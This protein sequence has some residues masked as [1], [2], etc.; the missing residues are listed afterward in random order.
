MKKRGKTSGWTGLQDLG[1]SS[2]P[3][4]GWGEWGEGAEQDV[5]LGDAFQL[6]GISLTLPAPL[7]PRSVDLLDRKEI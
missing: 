5:G 6:S 1:G 4:V 2:L 3:E 7:C